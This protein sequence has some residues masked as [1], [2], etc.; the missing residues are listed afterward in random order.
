M[1]KLPKLLP[2]IQCQEP[3]TYLL[4]ISF[5][6]QAAISLSI[7]NFSMA[8]SN[9]RYLALFLTRMHSSR[10]RTVRC[11]SHLGEGGVCQ[12]VVSTTVADGNKQR[13]RKCIRTPRPMRNVHRLKAKSLI[14]VNGHLTSD[15]VAQCKCCLFK[16]KILIEIILSNVVSW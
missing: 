9:H 15:C 2:T 8:Y 14:D 12:G 5:L 16:H 4:S 10:M 1:T 3:G 11:S 7:L 13:A 6:M